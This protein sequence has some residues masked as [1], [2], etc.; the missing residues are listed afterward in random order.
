M[1][2]QNKLSELEQLAEVLGNLRTEGKRIVHCHGVFDLLHVGHIKHFEAARHL[3]DVLVVTITPDRFVNKGDGRPVF[4]EALR[5]EAIAALQCVD[6]VAVNRW[7]TAV[8]AIRLLKPNLYVKGSE[9][10]NAQKDIT[11]KIVDEEEAVRQV[12]GRME[13]TDE[14][15]FSSS[16]LINRHTESLPPRVREYLS[17]FSARHALSDV[18]SYIERA[19][20]LRVLV[21]G[22]AIIDEYEYCEAIGKSSKE[23]ILALRHQSIERFAGGILAVGNHVANFCDQVGM[24]TM[25]GEQNSHEEFIREKLAPSIEPVFVRR[26]ASPTVVK[27]RIVEGY[28]FQKLLEIYDMNDGALDSE[29]DRGLC[30][31]LEQQ[32]PRYDVVIVVDFGHGMMSKEAV[33]ITCKRAKFLAVNAQANA[34]NRGFHTIS[35]Y[36]RADYVSKAEN[37]IRLEARDQRGEIRDIIVQIAE[38][39]KIP[40]LAVTRGSNGAILYDQQ[41]GLV[42]TPALAS[43]V[44]DRIG[45]GDAFLSVTA[46]CAAQGAPSDIVGL[47]GNVVGAQAVAMVGNRN[48]VDRLA[49]MRQI[50]TLLK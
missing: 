22:E 46:L 35:K 8:E 1:Q 27:R 44:V 12:G 43:K 33:Q 19:T 50:E 48:A 4:P 30:Q 14:I 36:P 31:A 29:D 45:A 26:K 28:F 9:Y 42:E 6:Y 17:E 41:N 39:L 7:P 34:G 40:R 49:V 23:P 16:R 2:P 13:F 18:L 5:A 15:T 38:R 47:I 10:R 24:V 32:V 25:L 11:G 3:G 20:N 37:E 21:I